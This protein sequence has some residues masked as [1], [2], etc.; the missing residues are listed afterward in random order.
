ML[1]C[2]SPIDQAVASVL[3]GNEPGLRLLCVGSGAE[4]LEVVFGGQWL[5]DL[6]LMD[7]LLQDMVASEVRGV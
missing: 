2:C 7:V 5:P 1:Q 6:I 4:A 3:L